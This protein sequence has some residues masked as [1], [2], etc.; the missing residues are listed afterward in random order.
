M[1]TLTIN[2]K[3]C[4]AEENQNLLQIALDNGIEIPHLCYH[5]KL[6]PYGGCRLCLVEVT[7]GEKTT[8]TTSCTCPAEESLQVQTDTSQIRKA[9]RLVMELILPMA[10]DSPRIQALAAKMGIEKPRFTF[11]EDGC[12][13]CGL[14][15]RACEEIVGTG[16]I[17][18]SGKGPERKVETPFAEEPDHCIGCAT[19]VFVCPT[20]CIQIDE[21]GSKKRISRWKKTLEM[22]K[23][24]KCGRPYI[25][26]EQVRY[27]LQKT[28]NSNLTEEWFE[29][30]PDCRQ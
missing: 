5:E 20:G 12:I 18:F 4:T 9:R 26:V 17:T 23:C 19:C 3:Q 7:K 13:K 14:C 24:Q 30:C 11:E 16:A 2:G 15:V 10:P 28:K 25:P 22:K 8:M 29:L 1:I 6:S 21:P 27:F